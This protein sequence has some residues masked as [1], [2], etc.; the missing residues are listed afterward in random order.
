MDLLRP[1]KL[2]Y[3]TAS[4]YEI[5]LHELDEKKAAL[6][7][8]HARFNNSKKSFL[9]LY[10]KK[11]EYD[12]MLIAG[13]MI[14]LL[15][16]IYNIKQDDTS[17][18]RIKGKATYEKILMLLKLPEKFDN[19]HWEVSFQQDLCQLTKYANSVFNNSDKVL[20]ILKNPNLPRM[21]KLQK[22]L[23]MR[24]IFKKE[25]NINKL[26]LNFS[27]YAKKTLGNL[28]MNAQDIVWLIDLT[29]Q[30]YCCHKHSNF[31]SFT[32]QDFRLSDL[33]LNLSIID[34]YDMFNEINSLQTKYEQL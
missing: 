19:D 17:V 5:D 12:A 10:T 1:Q 15:A 8:L 22:L 13:Y 24:D 14:E 3:I 18:E 30:Y 26:V 23:A 4:I 2:K 16:Q 11:F 25:K 7:I 28:G 21:E 6:N 29:Y 31:L 9:L 33:V 27:E 20:N 34:Y 32:E